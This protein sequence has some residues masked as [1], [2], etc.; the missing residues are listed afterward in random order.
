MLNGIIEKLA[1]VYMECKFGQ[2]YWNFEGDGFGLEAWFGN[3]IS[4]KHWATMFLQNASVV[5][6]MICII[7]LIA[8]V[9]SC[10]KDRG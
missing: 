3:Q 1:N 10:L 8:L 9:I 2:S 7:A 6:V 4:A 5:V